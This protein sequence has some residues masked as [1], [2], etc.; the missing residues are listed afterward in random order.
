M[1]LRLQV[2][3]LTKET[4]FVIKLGCYLDKIDL[5]RAHLSVA[6]YFLR[7]GV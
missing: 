5:C 1:I 6:L 7:Q 4:I 2:G 3:V